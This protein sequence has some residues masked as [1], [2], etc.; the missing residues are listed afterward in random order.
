MINSAKKGKAG[1][2]ASMETH[3]QAYFDALE[4]ELPDAGL[5]DRFLQEVEEPLFR[6]VMA[7][8]DGNQLRAAA[9]LGLNRNTLRK[10]IRAHGLLPE[11]PKVKPIV[12]RRKRS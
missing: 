2:A 8:C 7:L 1:L 3:L 5:Y 10:K 11:S 6:L 4:G 12:K 9:V